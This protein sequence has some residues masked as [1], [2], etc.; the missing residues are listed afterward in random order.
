MLAPRASMYCAGYQEVIFRLMDLFALVHDM[1]GGDEGSK[2]LRRIGRKG[3]EE[4]TGPGLGVVDRHTLTLSRILATEDQLL[5]L[6]GPASASSNSRA[7][8][9]V[10]GNAPG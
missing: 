2:F 10:A 6:S 3:F 7:S 8:T 9:C 1:G 5:Q 4:D